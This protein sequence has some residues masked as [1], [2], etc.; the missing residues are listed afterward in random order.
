M[1]Q[2]KNIFFIV[3]LLFGAVLFLIRWIMNNKAELRMIVYN[4]AIQN[5][6]SP[7]LAKLITAQAMHE[8]NNFNSRVFRLNNNAF[9]YKAVK[10]ARLQLGPGTGSPEGNSYARYANLT[11]SAR[12]VMGW[13]KRRWNAFKDIKTPEAFAEQLKA[14]GYFT[15]RTDN[16]LRGLRTWVNSF[17]I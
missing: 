1:K 5:G 7:E 11:D 12:D 6:A 4:V 14:H 17:V 16:Y 2:E 8:T 13:Y 10:G 9:G 3:S 15:D